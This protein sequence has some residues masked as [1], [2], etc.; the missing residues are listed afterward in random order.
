MPPPVTLIEGDMG[1][2]KTNTAVGLVVDRY[3]ADPNTRIMANF[4]LFG[5]RYV[6]RPTIVEIMAFLTEHNIQ[7]CIIVVDEAYIEAEAR[8]SMNPMTVLFTWYAQQMRKRKIELY[9]IVQNGRFVD[10]RFKWIMTT[11]VMCKYNEKNHNIQLTIKDIKK[12]TEK[13]VSYYAPQYWKYYDTYELP[14]IPQ[15]MIEKALEWA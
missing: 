10:W 7:E 6:Y 3:Q 11:R 4:H 12:G 9:I 13:I 2:G 15:K 5:I 8:R 14:H 1:S